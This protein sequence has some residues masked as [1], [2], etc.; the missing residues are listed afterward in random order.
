MKVEILTPTGYC[1][2]VTLAIKTALKAKEENIDKPVYVLGMLVHNEETIS[3]LERKGII[4]LTNADNDL[5]KLI[6]LI[7]NGSVIVF[8]AHGHSEKLDVIAKE[9]DLIIYD[10]TCPMVKN[11]ISLIKKKISEGYKV[12]FIGKKN[13]P[14]TE[15][16][17]SI[18][19]Q[20]YFYDSNILK[21]NQKTT[22]SMIFVANQTTLNYEDVKLIHQE[23]LEVFPD[24]VVQNEV[25]NTTR[26]R[27]SN[28]RS[29]DP[30]IDLIYVIGSKRS[31]NT[32]KLLEIAE[33]SFLNADVR[34]IL[35][36]DDINRSDLDNK[37]HILLVSGASTPKESVDMIY[38]YLV[39]LS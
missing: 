27:Q 17:L 19:D 10:A 14:E 37:K 25:C 4:T 32:M 7:P 23:I 6:E 29:A 12:L 8:T 30:S 9:K 16:M 13:H 31:N 33:T 2:G 5:F 18:S 24:A 11:N 35:N 38:D 20:V 36:I 34:L 26:L 1:H 3:F 15:A 39:S 22:N 28:L 21:V